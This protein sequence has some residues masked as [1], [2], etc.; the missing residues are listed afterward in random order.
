MKKITALAITAGTYLTLAPKTFAAPIA[1]CPGG[2]FG[3]LCNLKLNDFGGIVGTL[4]QVMFVLAVIIALAFLIFG[5]IK[6]ITSGGDSKNVDA[7]R[8][9]IVAALIGLA[10]VFLSFF[11]LNILLGFFGID[12]LQLSLPTLTNYTNR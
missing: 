6:W 3:T 1:V 7:A 12:I 9:M 4:I 11:I 2:Q 10:I 5:G 8:N